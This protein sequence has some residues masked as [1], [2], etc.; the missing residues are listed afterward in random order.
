MSNE[1]GLFESWAILELM[2]HVRMGGRIT[3]EERF[4]AKLGRIDVPDGEGFV[5]VYFGAS[6]VYRM[7]VCSEEAARAVAKGTVPKPVHQYELPKPEVKPTVSRAGASE[8]YRDSFT[9]QFEDEEDD[10]FE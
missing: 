6:S 5:T 4:G 7:T 9:D 8:P 10:D 1:S 3:E 2:G